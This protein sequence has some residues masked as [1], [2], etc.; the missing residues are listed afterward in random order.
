MGAVSMVIV[1]LFSLIDKIHKTGN[2][3]RKIGMSCPDSSV[4]DG[5]PEPFA[6]NISAVSVGRPQQCMYLVHLASGFLLLLL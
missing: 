2:I 6:E 5:N 1:G 3:C 4:E